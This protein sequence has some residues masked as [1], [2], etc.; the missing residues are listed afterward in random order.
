MSDR[1]G[2]SL[3]KRSGGQNSL[4]ADQTSYLKCQRKESG[5]VNSAE[6][7]QKQPTRDM[8]FGLPFPRSKQ[9]S[10]DRQRRPAHNAAIIGSRLISQLNLKTYVRARV[11]AVAGISL[12]DDE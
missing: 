10:N 4:R 3:K 6:R 11:V 5:K 1:V 12:N 9:P 7:T 8:P 2:N